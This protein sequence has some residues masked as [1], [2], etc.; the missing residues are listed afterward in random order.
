VQDPITYAAEHVNTTVE[1][2][3]SE[4]RLVVKT[5]GRGLIDK[6]KVIDVALSD[7]DKFALIPTIAAQ[8]VVGQ[9]TGIQLI[10]DTSYDAEF[11]FSYREGGKVQKKRVFVD[12]GDETFQRLLEALKT[13]R[14]AASLLDIDPADAQQQIGVISAGSALRL[15]VG[16]IVA[17]PVI[18]VVIVLLTRH[19]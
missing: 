3:L 12:S 17:V 6:L 10:S 9:G 11:I 5:K 15:I 13:A 1:L 16:I 14:P 18:M 8:N 4:S 2:T 19:H 7:L